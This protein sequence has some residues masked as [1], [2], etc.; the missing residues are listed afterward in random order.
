MHTG[1]GNSLYLL[2]NDDLVVLGPEGEDVA[3]YA[4]DRFS[5]ERYVGDFGIFSNGDVLL[6]QSSYS[7]SPAMW[8]TGLSRCILGTSRC[9]QLPDSGQRHGLEFDVLIDRRND[10]IYFAPGGQKTLLRGNSRGHWQKF[11][12]EAVGSPAAGM[13]MDHD[14][15][16][17]TLP[18]VST[19]GTVDITENE[20][21]FA[22]TPRNLHYPS[23]IDARP[24]NAIARLDGSW[25]VIGRESD[26]DGRVYIFDNQWEFVKEAPLPVG[27]AAFHAVMFRKEVL[28]SDRSGLKIYRFSAAGDYLGEFGTPWLRSRLEELKTAK[29]RCHAVE[30]VFAVV[31]L[32]LGLWF[33]WGW[34]CRNRTGM[35]HAMIE[36]QADTMTVQAQDPRIRWVGLTRWAKYIKYMNI[37]LMVIFIAQLVSLNKFMLKDHASTFAVVLAGLFLLVLLIPILSK[38]NQAWFGIPRIGVLGNMLVIETKKGHAVSRPADKCYFYSASK[39]LFVGTHK[40]ALLNPLYRQDDI[41]AEIFPLVAQAMPMSEGDYDRRHHLVPVTLAVMGLGCAAVAWFMMS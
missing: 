26:D 25:W 36:N 10:N 32:A 24:P 37:V 13:T 15:L 38:K 34:L 9:T 7:S 39:E 40:V 19:V 14:K 8:T 31:F 30:Q 3:Q 27:G 11:A 23:T 22:D 12:T 2:L 5:I 6:D 18:W 35:A 1:P 28:I 20:F 41:T 21:A 17:V 33:P 29:Q 4:L 16:Y